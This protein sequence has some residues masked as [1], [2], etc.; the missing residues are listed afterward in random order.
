ME[1]RGRPL[2]FGPDW[3]HIAYSYT[4]DPYATFDIKFFRSDS[5]VSPKNPILYPKIAKNQRKTV[6]DRCFSDRIDTILHTVIHQT[7]TQLLTKNFFGRT[8][9]C[10]PK[11]PFCT[12]K[13]PKVNVRLWEAVFLMWFLLYCIQSYLRFI[14]HIFEEKI[15]QSYS[16]VYQKNANL[17][18][19]INIF[20][21]NSCFFLWSPT[22]CKCVTLHYLKMVKTS[23]TAILHSSLWSFKV[24]WNLILEI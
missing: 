6:E 20:P 9:G 24:F 12:Q 16:G 11:M 22:N 19:K 10:P 17:G 2:F 5:R 21:E 8:P 18:F 3:D 13:S 1:D 4:S 15:F 14:T 23:M 7:H